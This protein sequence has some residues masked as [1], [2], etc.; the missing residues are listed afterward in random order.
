M[1]D[2]TIFY[3]PLWL[4]LY[5][6]ACSAVSVGVANSVWPPVE[7]LSDEMFWH[8]SILETCIVVLALIA[9]IIAL[10]MRLKGFLSNKILGAIGTQIIFILG[11]IVLGYRLV[12]NAHL[13][14]SS[15]VYGAT[16]FVWLGYLGFHFLL[17][18]CLAV[19][20]FLSISFSS[21]RLLH[22]VVLSANLIAITLA[23][24][25]WG[26]LVHAVVSCGL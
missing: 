9:A 21:N 3:A 8:T 19:I 7:V 2:C 10:V 20:S 24:A 11:V 26:A 13:G 14:F 18:L 5:Y 25:G 17:A 22:S 16:F 23:S 12:D 15:Q 1:I 4:K 6:Q